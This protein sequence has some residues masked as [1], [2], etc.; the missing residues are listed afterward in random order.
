ME[1]LSLASS[2]SAN[3]YILSDGHTKLLIECGLRYKEL[4]K[5]LDFKVADIAG[6]LITHEHADHSKSATTLVNNGIPVYAS[7]GTAAELVSGEFINIIEADVKFTVGTFEIL[8]FDTYHDVDES[9]GFFIKSTITDEKMM[10][11]T[12]TVNID[13]SMDG[14]DIIAIE[15][16]HDV[17]IMNNKKQW[18]SESRPQRWDQMIKIMN[19]IQ[20]THMSIDM[21]E[22]YLSGVDLSKCKEIYLLHMSGNYSNESIFVERIRKLCGAHI[23]VTACGK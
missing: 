12:D 23:S 14:L 13:K 6:C 19:R 10:F 15:C 2:S 16:N 17:N 18:M 11:A 1:F 3:A 20:N 8:P 21:C 4:Q 22:R 7:Y 5:R 9:L